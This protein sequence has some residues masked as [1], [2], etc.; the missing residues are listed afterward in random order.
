MCY[1]CDDTVVLPLRL[2]RYYN[3]ASYCSCENNIAKKLLTRYCLN[4]NAVVVKILS[5][6]RCCCYEDTVAM[7]MLF[8]L[9]CCHTDSIM[10]ILLHWRCC[11]CEDTVALKL[12]LWGYCCDYD[13]VVVYT[14]AH[15]SC[16][17]CGDTVAMKML[18]WRHCCTADVLVV[19]ILLH[20]RC[21]CLEGTIAVTML[22]LCRYFWYCF[23]TVIVYLFFDTVIVQ[24]LS[25]WRRRCCADTLAMTMLLLCKYYYNDDAVA[26]T[27]WSML[28]PPTTHMHRSCSCMEQQNLVSNSTL[29]VNSALPQLTDTADAHPR[30]WHH[31]QSWRSREQYCCRYWPCWRRS[32]S[33][34]SHG[35]EAI[36][37]HVARILYMLSN[38]LNSYISAHSLYVGSTAKH[39]R[40]R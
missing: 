11:C 17:C 6:W 15:C 21:C 35:P 22:F 2:W 32:R 28:T 14:L 36:T 34:Y 29:G 27:S 12:F 18:F 38:K 1:C 40:Q 33:N 24:T 31:R 30:R 7:K 23:D 37:P 13:A 16:S 10:K 20:W 3:V 8:W 39:A 5:H 25:Q 9:C 4:D 26:T 19:D